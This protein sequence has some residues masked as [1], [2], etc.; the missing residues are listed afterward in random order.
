MISRALRRRIAELERLAPDFAKRREEAITARDAEFAVKA[1][2]H[3]INLGLLLHYGEPKIDEPLTAAWERCLEEFPETKRI[4]DMVH[5]FGCHAGAVADYVA[6][7]VL[8]TLPGADETEKFSQLF[9]TAPPW[10]IYYTWGDVTAHFLGLPLPD[11]S[12]VKKFVRSEAPIARWPAKGK[13][14]SRPWP[15][16]DEQA[17]ERNTKEYLHFV[18]GLSD[19]ATPR[20]R[21]R[22]AATY[23]RLKRFPKRK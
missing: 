2:I 12:S 5:P 1:R 17:R 6:D 10:L 19:T 7:R 11:V 18:L 9:A 13:F 3:A 22:A 14:E 20:E 16:I 4:A 23:L 21:G 8:S 15:E